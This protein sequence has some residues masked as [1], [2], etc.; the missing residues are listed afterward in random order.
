MRLLLN[1]AVLALG[2]LAPL[3]C[4]AAGADS[5]WISYRDAY[6]AMVVFEKY[7]K[8]KSLLQHQVQVVLA[9]KMA[10]GE[11]L[12][13]VLN[14]PNSQLNLVLDATGR[15]VFPLLKAAYDDN[16]ALI[17][18][19]KLGPFKMR[20]RVSLV[21]RA[22]GI[23]DMAE[24]RAACEQALGYARYLDATYASRSC[25]GVRFGFSKTGPLPT[26]TVKRG[27]PAETTELKVQEGAIFGDDASD[28]FRVAN[29]RFGAYAGRVQVSTQEAPL[30]IVPLFEGAA[31]PTVPAPSAA[32]AVPAEAAR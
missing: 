20:A 7:G 25:A 29:L 27:Q 18:S 17:L 1:Q 32:S 3:L 24:L 26:L 12:R 9:E 22:D 4:H 21:V 8:P 16:A 19:R 14:G 31:A 13:L 2:T 11:P 6:R 15:T 5:D 10:P 23:Y 28:A 30:A